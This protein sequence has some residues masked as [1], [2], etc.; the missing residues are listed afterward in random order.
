[1]DGAGAWD[2]FFILLR[3][4]ISISRSK[5]KWCIETEAIRA[6]GVSPV[7]ASGNRTS[8]SPPDNRIFYV[9]F[10]V[11]YHGFTFFNG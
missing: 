7:N 8:S 1:M 11:H 9:I 6:V 3:Y 5:E 4:S 10:K 2:S